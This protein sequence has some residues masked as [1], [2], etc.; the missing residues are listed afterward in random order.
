[1]NVIP[2]P[3]FVNSFP[4]NVNVSPASLFVNVFPLNVNVSPAFLFVNVFPAC[5]FV[6]VFPAS[7]FV[8]TFPCSVA[9]PCDA[10]PLFLSSSAMLVVSLPSRDEVS[11]VAAVTCTI[12]GTSRASKA[13]RP[14]LEMVDVKG[15]RTEK[16]SK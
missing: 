6:N 1:M 8:N 9:T 15:R 10:A 3:L 7:L 4:L 16:S 12:R 13:K 2:F 5:L 14:I 11:E